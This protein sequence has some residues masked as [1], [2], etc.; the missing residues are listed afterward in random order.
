MFLSS[1][2][3]YLS[4]NDKYGTIEAAVFL[5]S[6]KEK[7]VAGNRYSSKGVWEAR[8]A[9]FQAPSLRSN[10]ESPLSLC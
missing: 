10:S 5:N 3:K 7:D 8:G 6:H 1:C 2:Y 4:I 9:V